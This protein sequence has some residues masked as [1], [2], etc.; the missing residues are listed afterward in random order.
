MESSLDGMSG[1][2]KT[3]GLPAPGCCQLG[4]LE[5]GGLGKGDG[6]VGV[7]PGWGLYGVPYSG[8]VLGCSVSMWVLL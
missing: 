4:T 2:W 1:A 8:F 6:E 7:G 3:E 5:G